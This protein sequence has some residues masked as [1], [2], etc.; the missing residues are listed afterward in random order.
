MKG[1]SLVRAIS[2]IYQWP[3][4]RRESDWPDTW[5]SPNSTEEC[6]TPPEA[7]P[8]PMVAFLGSFG[9][10]HSPYFEYSQPVF[11]ELPSC[12]GLFPWILGPRQRFTRERMGQALGCRT[13]CSATAKFRGREVSPL[14]VRSRTRRCSRIPRSQMASAVRLLKERSRNYG[15]KTKGEGTEALHVTMMFICEV[16]ASSFVFCFCFCFLPARGLPLPRG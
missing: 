8:A 11:T 5:V 13:Y 10:W 14:P 7:S 9:R 2:T 15:A 4:T 16:G 3:V 12:F 1:N 6:G